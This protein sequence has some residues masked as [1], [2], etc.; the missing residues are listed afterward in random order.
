MRARLASASRGAAGVGYF[1][2]SI[3]FT[4]STIFERDLLAPKARA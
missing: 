1:Y 3:R 4:L 2:F